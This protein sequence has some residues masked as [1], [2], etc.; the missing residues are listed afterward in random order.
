MGNLEIFIGVLAS[1]VVVVFAYLAIKLR[2]IGKAL[3][4]LKRTGASVGIG[5]A[6]ILAI[7]IGVV[8]LSVYSPNAESKE[9]EMK[10]FTHTT[11]YAGVDY[12][13]RSI[14]CVKGNGDDNLTSNFGLRQNLVKKG[15]ISVM[16]TYTHHSC[17]LNED[18]PTYDAVGMSIEWTF[19][20]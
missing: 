1:S 20:R 8:L 13:H 19:F 7:I 11:L 17:A 14:F 2:G 12:D 16:A 18:K 9:S 5:L 6:T 3:T 10:W 15:D 4:H